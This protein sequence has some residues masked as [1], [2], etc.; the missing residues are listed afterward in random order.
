MAKPSQAKTHVWRFTEENEWEGERWERWF[1]ASAELEDKLDELKALLQKHTPDSYWLK[2]VNDFPDSYDDGQLEEC[3]YADQF[4]DDEE[5][6]GDCGYCG[7]AEGYFAPEGEGELN[8]ETL[9]LALEY[10]RGEGWNGDGQDP[11]YKL[12]LFDQ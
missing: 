8:G 1:E 4:E 11:L 6:C 12:R 10:Y 9:E 3:E 7:G 2:R 5:G